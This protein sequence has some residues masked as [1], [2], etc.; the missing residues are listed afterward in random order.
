MTITIERLLA[1]KSIAD[2]DGILAELGAQDGDWLPVGGT[3]SNAANIETAKSR[4]A[5]LIERIVNGV[6]AVLEMEMTRRNEFDNEPGSPRQAVERWF[7]VPGGDWAE[8]SNKI[9]DAERTTWA[10]RFC[11]ISFLDS[12]IH[13]HPTIVARDFGIGQHP[14]NFQ[15][16]LLRLGNSFKIRFKYVCGSYGHGGSSTF[17]YCP[18]AVIISRRQPDLL[19][20]ATDEIGWTIVRQNKLRQDLK[21]TVYEYYAPNKLIPSLPASRD[22]DPG[23]HIAHIQYDGGRIGGP[24]SREGYRSLRHFL[25]DGVLPFRLEDHRGEEVFRRNMFGARAVLTADGRDQIRYENRWAITLPGE[26]ELKIRCWVFAINP[27]DPAKLSLENYLDSEGSADTMPVTLNG[28]RH[29]ALQRS[30]LKEAKLSLLQKYLLLQVEIDSLSR[31]MRAGLFTSNREGLI[32]EGEAIARLKT[33]IIEALKEDPEI[34]RIESEILEAT[35]KNADQEAAS[36]ARELLNQLI[37]VGRKMGTGR[38]R[39]GDRGREGD[40][41][42]VAADPP[43]YIRVITRQD[44]IEVPKGGGR[45]ITLETDGPDN[46]FRR[47]E[48]RATLQIT[49]AEDIGIALAYD[50]REL[51]EGRLRVTCTSKADAPEHAATDIKVM[52]EMDGLAKPLEDSRAI[53]VAPP[54]IPY[55]PVDPPTIFELVSR[56]VPLPVHSTG[57]TTVGLFL[58]GPNDLFDRKKG[59]ASIGVSGLPAGAR[60]ARIRGPREGRI[61]VTLELDGTLPIGQTFEFG[62]AVTLADGSQLNVKRECRIVLPIERQEKG[63]GRRGASPNYEL[64]PVTREVWA[65]HQWNETSVGKHEV[66]ADENGMDKLLLYVNMDN[67]NFVQEQDRR[68]NKGQSEDALKGV[69]D[70]YLSYIGYHLFQQYEDS[71]TPAVPNGEEAPRKERTDEDYQ[72]ELRR[73]SQTVVLALRGLTGVE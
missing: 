39:S 58:N 59:Q 40:D 67:E 13:K 33:E 43:T 29:G 49:T 3:D 9:T 71:K 11:K 34:A 35:R 30:L 44:P 54:P 47:R 32:E 37:D 45:F 73:V 26:G 62:A 5:P 48:R 36:R 15:S 17:R 31:N 8:F 12:G 50:V 19:N 1:A 22:F 6:D 21:G 20:G 64:I 38:G 52:L 66:K 53:A 69:K 16:S 61:H 56:K 25:F 57:K 42:F 65:I 24:V 14:T 28:Q 7:N 2:V 63:G 55:A 41:E 68:Y 51:S 70:R 10:T 27:A 23:T 60:V 4:V 46:M 18:Y 72:M